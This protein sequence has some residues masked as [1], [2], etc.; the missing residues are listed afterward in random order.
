MT[1]HSSFLLDSRLSK[2]ILPKTERWN[3]PPDALIH[4]S[5]TPF[6]F[7]SPQILN[8]SFLMIQE[9]SVHMHWPTRFLGGIIKTSLLSTFQSAELN[10]AVMRLLNMKCWI[11][12]C[13][14]LIVEGYASANNWEVEWSFYLR[15]TICWGCNLLRGWAKLSA[16]HTL[17]DSNFSTQK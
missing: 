6:S 7:G 9:C 3:E 13:M 15:D 8:S 16:K 1:I 4:W 5:F 12:K 11:S 2:L 17:W 14:N 10:K